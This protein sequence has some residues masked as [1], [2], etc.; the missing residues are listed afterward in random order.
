M[1]T[2]ERVMRIMT[3]I[4]IGATLGTGAWILVSGLQI[5]GGEFSAPARHHAPSQHQAPAQTSPHHHGPAQPVC[6][7]VPAESLAPPSVRVEAPP[8]QR[9]ARLDGDLR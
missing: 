3:H 1:K 6:C 4:N 2:I 7:F 5:V 9:F 8:A